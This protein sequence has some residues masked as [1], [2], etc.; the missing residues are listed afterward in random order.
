MASPATGTKK[1]TAAKKRTA[2]KKNQSTQRKW[3][4]AK[5]EEVKVPSGN[6]A[7]V[8]RPGME[9]FLFEGLLPDALQPLVQEAI[10]T[11]RGLP[12]AKI[13]KMAESEEAVKDMMNTIDR[14]VARILVEPKV[15]WH[16]R[17]VVDDEGAPVM[18]AY[19]DAD[20]KAQSRQLLEDIPENERVDAEGVL[21]TDDIDFE[22][23]SFLFQYAVGGTRDLE[24][25]RGES[26]ETLESIRDGDDVPESTE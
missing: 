20:G 8:K 19:Q 1:K 26:D 9:V 10:K 6:L 16:K 5:A 7:L 17:P 2:P 13:K 12:A 3:K 14:V 21:Y 18:E 22:D 4:R 23:K 25:F 11:G 24:R 15:I